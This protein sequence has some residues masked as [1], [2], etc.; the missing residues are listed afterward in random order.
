MVLTTQAAE[1]SVRAASRHT[2]CK[3]TARREDGVGV[4]D[5]ARGVA[6]TP[7]HLNPVHIRWHKALFHLELG[8]YGAAL[9]LYD[10]PIRAM[11]SPCGWPRCGQLVDQI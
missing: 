10:G 4:D 6:V 1:F 8:Q 2:C 11:T 5:G 7:G 9:A 3:M